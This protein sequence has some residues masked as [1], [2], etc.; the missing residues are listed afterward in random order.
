MF[1]IA[2]KMLIGNRVKYLGIIFGVVFAALLIAQ[3]ASIFCGLM[4]LTVSQIR[5][6]EGPSIWV[7]DKN[8]QFVD[9]IKPLSDNELF[10]VKGVPGVDWAVRFYKGIA[11]ARLQEGNYEQMILLG[12]DDATLVGAPEGI[13]MGSIADLRKPD[14]VIMDDAGYRRIWPGEPFRLGRVFEMNDHR[15]VVVALTKAS[16]TFQSFPIVYTRYSQAVTFAPPERKVLSFVLADAAPGVPVEEVCG[17]IEAQT[18][19]Q[20]LTR[21]QFLWKTVRY[22]MQKTG[23]PVNFGI[24]VFLGFIVGTAIAGQ[25]F[26]L[27]TVENIRQFGALKAMGTSNWMILLM[28]LSQ[29]LQVGLVG[30]GVGVGLAALFGWVSRGLSRLSFFMPWQV[31]AITA[32]AVFVIVLLASLLSIRKVLIVDPAI[33]F[34]G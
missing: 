30:Y 24:T 12:L 26:Y 14:A 7:M 8:V 5:D 9:D 2:W 27:F 25:T 32:A 13:F 31:L 6:V 22:Y 1:W 10:R 17:R 20:A 21:E 34:R 29:A 18:G 11:R 16:R 15:A 3:Q 4:S 23:I 33:V 19:L 28:V